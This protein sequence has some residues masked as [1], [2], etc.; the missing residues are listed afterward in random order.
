MN[1]NEYGIALQ[2][3]VSF[4]MSSNTSLSFTFT[5]PSG[6]TLTTI[7]T[8]GSTQITTPVGIF[9]P[10]TW[11]QYTFTAGQVS[12]AGVWQVRLTYHDASPAQ[13]ISSIGKFTVLP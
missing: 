10:N 12:E 13:L 11:A 2:M 3:G 6:T 4:D 5:K 9:A 8:L 1:V 7:A